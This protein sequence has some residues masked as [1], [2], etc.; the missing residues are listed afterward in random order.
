MDYSIR[1]LL[2]SALL[3]TGAVHAAE[4]KGSDKSHKPKSQ[5]IVRP[6]PPV[7]PTKAAKPNGPQKSDW[8]TSAGAQ[9]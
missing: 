7:K 2:V 9:R 3:L 8:G 4:G 6:G 1:V 5:I